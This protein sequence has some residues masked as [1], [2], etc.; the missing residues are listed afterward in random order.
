MIMCLIVCK[1]E[2]VNL[3]IDDQVKNCFLV[4]NQ[5]IKKDNE[6]SLVIAM[7]QHNMANRAMKQIPFQPIYMQMSNEFNS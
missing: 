7:K 3:F 2:N 5:G 6:F 4:K 1:N